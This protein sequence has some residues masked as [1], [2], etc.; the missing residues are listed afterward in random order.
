MSGL[1]RFEARIFE[2]PHL[3]DRN[4]VTLAVRDRNAYLMRDGTWRVV[5]E[6]ERLPDDHGVELPRA[7]IEAIAVAVQE[8]QGHTSHA[9][10]EARI[11]REWLTVERDRTDRI[12]DH[13]IYEPD[14]AA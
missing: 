2:G 5:P 9:D 10:T 1:E 3:F 7:A 6:G 12:L 4:V 13:A 8:W 11:L 14:P